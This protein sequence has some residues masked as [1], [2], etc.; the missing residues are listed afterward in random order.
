MSYKNELEDSLRACREIK[1]L[2]S[3]E[4]IN[5]DTIQKK[6]EKDENLDTINHSLEDKENN[7]N[8]QDKGTENEVTET[9][10]FLKTILSVIIC[11]L[12][13]LILAFLITKFVAHHTSVEGSSM[14]NTL[15]D[16]DE[17]IVE[18]ISY[19]LHEPERFDVIVFP[20]GENVNYIKRII[21]L[22]KEAIQIVDGYVY[23]NG[24]QLSDP[25]ANERIEDAGLV[26]EEMV[27]GEN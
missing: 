13:A 27:L 3:S 8:L 5:F 17:I 9:H 20:N 2:L 10:S 19:Y 14:E 21:G 12:T 1:E 4:E 15:T 23:I 18:N 26:S 6:P 11:V 25:F 24:K 22:P 16:G 7:T